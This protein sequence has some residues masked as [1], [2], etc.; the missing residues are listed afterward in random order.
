MKPC[1]NNKKPIALL[2]VDALQNDDAA[3]LSQH[4]QQ[5]EGCR[6]YEREI[7]RVTHRLRSLESLTD[8]EILNEDCLGALEARESN[9]HSVGRFTGEAPALPGMLN[10]RVLVP[11]FCAAGVTILLLLILL[12]HPIVIPSEQRRTA[13]STV[14]STAS[15]LPPTI[16]NYRAVANKS[17][18]E[19]DELLARQARKRVPVPAPFNPTTIAL[20]GTGD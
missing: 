15:D 20:L 7:S 3:E 4:L 6:E 17:L 16:G 2:V 9:V 5:C 8:A 1:W 12:R 11:A 19:L 14:S 18:D 13:V 10:W